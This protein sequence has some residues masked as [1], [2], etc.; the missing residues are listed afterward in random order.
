MFQCI[1]GI[2]GRLRGLTLRV[3][4]KRRYRNGDVLGMDPVGV[5]AVARHGA[6]RRTGRQVGF[7]AITIVAFI[8]FGSLLEGIPAIV[9]FAPLMLPVARSIGVLE[10]HYSMVVILAM[11]IGPCAPPFRVGVCDARAIGKL[12]PGDAMRRVWP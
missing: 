3:K 6:G 2:E 1:D 5:L 9:V 8:V 10:V 7:M 4:A 11:G 12:L